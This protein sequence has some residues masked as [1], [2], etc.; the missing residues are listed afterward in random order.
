MA[1]APEPLT[2]TVEETA[3]LLRI[4]RDQAYEAVRTGQIR[5]IRI[6]RRLLV[7]RAS[8]DALLKGEAA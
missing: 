2:Y 1:D 8:L 3:K 6:G 4:G 5:S 7:P